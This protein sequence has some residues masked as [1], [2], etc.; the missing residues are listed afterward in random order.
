[1]PCS[2]NQLTRQ[3]RNQTSSGTALSDTVHDRENGRTIVIHYSYDLMSD[4]FPH[5]SSEKM[6][7]LLKCLLIVRDLPKSALEET[8][9]ELEEIYRFHIN[10]SSQD[11]VFAATADTIKGKLGDVQVRPP[12]VL[13][14]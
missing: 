3:Y 1:M 8:A 14:P 7:L 9:E 12:I 2:P 13:E 6:M 10:R 5:L 11:N 4:P